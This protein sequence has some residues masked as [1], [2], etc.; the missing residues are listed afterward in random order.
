MKLAV[1]A[2]G[3]DRNSPVDPHFA[4]ARCFLVVDMSSGESTVCNNVDLQQTMHLAGSQAAGM[5]ISL[6]VR[7]VVAG[8]IGPRAFATFKSAGVRVFQAAAGTVAEAIESFRDGIL[9]ELT[10]ANAEEHW[11]RPNK[12]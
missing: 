10:G 8:H 11:P 3:N 2:E 12:K 6:G 4:R 1:A 5:L 7:A 9:V